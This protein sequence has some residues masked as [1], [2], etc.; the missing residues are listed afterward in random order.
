[1]VIENLVSVMIKQHRELQ[2]DLATAKSLSVATEMDTK[3]IFFQLELFK[4]NLIEH[5]KLENGTFYSDLIRKM[6]EKG[7]DTTKT[8]L[9]I[10]EMN[11]IAQAVTGFLDNYDSEEKIR[12]A[13]E[14]FINDL[15][16]IIRA[17]NIRIE[18]EEAGVYS[19]WGL[20]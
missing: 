14:V 3:E 13:P 20:F 9:F 6:K 16:G 17:L 12:H 11:V 1:M 8:E 4:H 15:E 10:N 7:V 5:L 2:K 19:Y 18:S